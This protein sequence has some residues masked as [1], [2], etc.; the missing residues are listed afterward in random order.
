MS[1]VFAY[2]R[3]STADQSTDK[4]VAEIQGRGYA[5]E[6]HRIVEENIS[7]AVPAVE[8]PGFQ[9]LLHKLE[10]GDTL[11]VTKLDRLGRNAMDIES[12]VT[13]LRSEGVHLVVLQLGGVD[14][15]SPAGELQLR[16]M[17]AFA[18]FERDLIAER[19]TAGRVI[20]QAK[21]VKFGRKQVFDDE[22]RAAIRAKFEQSR[23]VSALAKEYDT[24]RTMIQRICADLRKETV[25]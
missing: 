2:C 14:L 3:V 23:N 17:A 18:Q 8:R 21:G 16:M 9:K 12:T 22:T 20:A 15:T 5:I 19:L 7:G 11:I 1:R 24:S 6:Q 4:Q 13:H 10:A 25:Q